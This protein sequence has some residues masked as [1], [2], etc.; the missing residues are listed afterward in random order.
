MFLLMSIA[1]QARLQTPSC[2]RLRH[3]DLEASVMALCES[4]RRG[5]HVA[6]DDVDL[7]RQVLHWLYRASEP[8]KSVVRPYLAS[9]FV[10]S[11]LNCWHLPQWRRQRCELEMKTLGVFCSGLLRARA[12]DALTTLR[13]A[14]AKRWRWAE[15]MLRLAADLSGGVT[16]GLVLV[17]TPQ[18]G[19]VQR[20]TI[21]LP[22]KGISLQRRRPSQGIHW[23]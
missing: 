21:E 6:C 13:D 15:D 12:P 3:D 22:E 11:H 4:A 7:V 18:R 23:G 9:L 16:R 19:L 14:A 8:L 1:D 10:A 20:T 17:L 5:A 2:S